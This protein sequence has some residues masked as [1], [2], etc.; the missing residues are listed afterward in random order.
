MTVHIWL[1][2]LT[3]ENSWVNTYMYCLMVTTWRQKEKSKNL[4]YRTHGS[5]LRIR[6]QSRLEITTS[7]MM[8]IRMRL[9]RMGL[10]LSWRMAMLGAILI[11]TVRFFITGFIIGAPCRRGSYMGMCSRKIGIISSQAISQTG[12]GN[13]GNWSQDLAL[14][15]KGPSRTISLTA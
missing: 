1:V 15:T 13:T 2:S 6:Y 9:K 8:M 11:S 10:T 4:R 3:G 7:M 5:K 14:N 12:K